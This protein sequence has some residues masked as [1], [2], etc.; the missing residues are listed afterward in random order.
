MLLVLEGQD[1]NAFRD[2]GPSIDRRP[3]VAEGQA[4]LVMQMG[5]VQTAFTVVT[6]TDEFESQGK[7]ELFGAPHQAGQR[8]LSVGANLFAHSCR[9][10][11]RAAFHLMCE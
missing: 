7:Q 10:W 8:V 4:G 3:L 11:A 2:G 5:R 6:R 1:G 9:G